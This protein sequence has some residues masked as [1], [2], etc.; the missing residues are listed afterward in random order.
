[1]ESNMAQFYCDRSEIDENGRIYLCA[2]IL[3]YGVFVNGECEEMAV[4]YFNGISTSL[5]HLP[6][7]GITHEQVSEFR[8]ILAIS[9]ERTAHILRAKA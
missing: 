7:V 5:P 6:K 3:D 8:S 1:M 9:A 2:P 4:E